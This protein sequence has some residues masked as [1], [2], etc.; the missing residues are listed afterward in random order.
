MT[1]RRQFK[2]QFLRVIDVTC[3]IAGLVLLSPVIALIVAF[4]LTDDG[5]PVIFRQTRVGK[6]GTHFQIWKFRTMKANSAGAPVTSAGDRRITRVGR[7]L[8]RLKL[9]ELPQLVN[10]LVGE[11]SLIGPRPEVPEFVRIDD[12]TWQ[13]VLSVRPGVTDLA[14]LVYRDEEQLLESLPDPIRSYRDTILPAKLYLNLEYQQ[15]RTISRD[16]QLLAL[17]LCY[18]F[19]PMSFSRARLG[20]LFRCQGAI[21]E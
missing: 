8:R 13:A 21:H 5:L 16:L 3:S 14:T 20:Q 12:P 7:W 1:G 2:S 10:V 18:S 11:M 6:G 9:D 4:I 15:S 19:F 17:T